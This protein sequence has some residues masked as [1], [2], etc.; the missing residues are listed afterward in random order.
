MDCETLFF[1]EARKENDNGIA[2]NSMPTTDTKFLHRI[3]Y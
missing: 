2:L 3:L 1:T